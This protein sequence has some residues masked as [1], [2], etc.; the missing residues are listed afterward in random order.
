MMRNAK[1]HSLHWIAKV[2]NKVLLG[3][4]LL[5]FTVCRPPG[6]VVVLSPPEASGY[7]QT[8]IGQ[9]VIAEAIRR[10]NL[11]IQNQVRLRLHPGW[12]PDQPP[13]TTPD[14]KQLTILPVYL[15][16]PEQLGP[17]AVA[18]VP[19]GKFCIFVNSGRVRDLTPAFGFQPEQ[20]VGGDRDAQNFWTVI[21]LHEV[22]HVFYSDQIREEQRMIG[23]AESRNVAR[24]MAKLVEFR[25]D[26]FAAIQIKITDRPGT[27]GD[28]AAGLAP[29]V[30]YAAAARYLSSPV[31]N[32]PSLDA[33]G[34]AAE[35]RM[36]IGTVG[37]QV[38]SH[39]ADQLDQLSEQQRRELAWDQGFSHPN[40][41]LRFLYMASILDP[42]NWATKKQ[43]Y[44]F[45]QVRNQKA[46]EALYRS[47]YTGLR[48]GI[49][50]TPPPRP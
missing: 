26:H 43:L 19:K 30:E 27:R 15:V 44:D 34:V 36:L 23:D 10:V 4:A 3:G 14:G 40:L 24:D 50:P 9:T 12:V 31:E 49:E 48:D 29:V 2:L 38:W 8:V 42:G 16:F 5:L 1:L 33:L 35:L 6:S 17:S 13:T 37:L 11:L 18:F 46:Q 32:V 21:L 7:R 20:V 22:G 45:L 25:A 28:W 41:G 39:L 47:E